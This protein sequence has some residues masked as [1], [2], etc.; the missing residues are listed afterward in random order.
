M[1]AGGF[2]GG[3]RGRGLDIV[4]RHGLIQKKK[5]KKNA[6]SPLFIKAI[7]SH[8]I[9]AVPVSSC[10]WNIYFFLFLSFSLSL[11]SCSRLFFRWRD[12]SIFFS[13]IY[14]REDSLES[15]EKIE[16][17]G[18]ICVC[19]TFRIISYRFGQIESRYVICWRSVGSSLIAEEEVR[20]CRGFRMQM[21]FDRPSSLVNNS[22]SN[23]GNFFQ[24]LFLFFSMND[25]F[26]FLLIIFV[27]TFYPPEYFV[28]NSRYI[29]IY[30]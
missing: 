11:S 16:R 1:E 4:H 6:T 8:Y 29:Y 7:L 18:F 3:D 14:F 26:F 25:R 15:I 19:V 22:F 12:V 17:E 10:Y 27:R 20:F 24:E 5:K 9:V 23:G 13:D 30:R 28:R 2:E 21:M